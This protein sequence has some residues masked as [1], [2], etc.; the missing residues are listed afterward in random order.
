MTIVSMLFLSSLRLRVRKVLVAPAVGHAGDLQHQVVTT[1]LDHRGGEGR[2]FARHPVDQ[3]TNAAGQGEDDDRA[4]LG[5]PVPATN[6]KRYFRC[7]LSFLWSGM[8]SECAAVSV[9]ASV[10]TPMRY[11]H[12]G[13]SGYAYSRELLLGR[14]SP[15]E[16][17]GG[18]LAAR[19]E[20]QLVQDV[21]DVS[22]RGAPR[23]HQLF[24]DLRVRQSAGKECDNLP[25]ARGERARG[26]S[27]CSRRCG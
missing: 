19:G 25:F 18:D 8:P 14:G 10:Y 22:I 3:V 12:L 6:A 16:R 21:A 2:V 9:W 13:A 15:L 1:R 23:D 20:A 17:P 4:G 26:T 24:C 5:G 7:I 27:G 11:T